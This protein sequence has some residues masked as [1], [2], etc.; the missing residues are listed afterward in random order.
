[1]VPQVVDI[2]TWLLTSLAANSVARLRSF[3]M[4]KFIAC[5]SKQNSKVQ[6]E[7]APQNL[8]F[9]HVIISSP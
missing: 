9:L 4:L 2:T 8:K 7:Q 3:S 6:T 1:L 5:I